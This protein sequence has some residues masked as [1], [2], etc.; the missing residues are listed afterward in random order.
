MPGDGF[1]VRQQALAHA[2]LEE[3][4]SG[5]PFGIARDL[6]FPGR[7]GLGPGLMD[8][9]AVK[10]PADDASKEPVQGAD[11]EQQSFLGEGEIAAQNVRDGDCA[12]ED[13]DVKPPGNPATNPDA[14]FHKPS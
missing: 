8:L 14:E 12:A 7:P 3:I 4:G 13:T 6:H 2:G 1:G 10:R 9:D 11:Q 5:V